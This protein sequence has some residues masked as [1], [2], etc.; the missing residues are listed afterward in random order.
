MAEET[1]PV[2]AETTPTTEQKPAGKTFTEEYVT[3]LREEAKGYRLAVKKLNA[4]IKSVI[5]LKD[6]DEISDDKINS[7]KTAMEQS[8]KNAEAKANAKLI[9][10]SI[11]ELT[12]YDSKL[13]DR[14]VD[15]SKLKI[16]D[17]GTVEGLKEAVEALAAEFPQIKKTQTQAPTGG[18]NPPG[19]GTKT[20]LQQLEETYNAALKAGNMGLVVATKNRLFELSKK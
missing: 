6:E 12:E 9:A 17:D 5:G 4:Q 3:S 2:V 7:F 1:T 11:K 13:I 14:L 8:I 20:E 15:K 10:A 16:N 18:A 19:G